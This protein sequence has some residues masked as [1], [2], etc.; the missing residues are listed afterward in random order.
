M[1][2]FYFIFFFKVNY[3]FNLAKTNYNSDKCKLINVGDDDG[4]LGG[5]LELFDSI[6]SGKLIMIAYDCD[7]NFEPCNKRGRKAHWALIVGYLLPVEAQIVEKYSTTTIN[8]NNDRLSSLFFHLNAQQVQL[9]QADREILSKKYTSSMKNGDELLFA[10]R[11]VHV[12]C[13]HGK[14]KHMGV[15]RLKSLL[16]SNKQLEE[17]DHEKC[18]DELFV[19]PIDGDLKQTLSSK[20]L[21]FY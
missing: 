4:G 12:I 21:V 18:S 13:M 9:D 16:N 6:L 19:K 20:A 5:E 17:I 10:N 11:D 14:S 1:I 15:W 3:L 8:N 2:L 7:F